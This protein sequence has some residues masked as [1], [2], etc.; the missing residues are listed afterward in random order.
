VLGT[1]DGGFVVD[2]AGGEN[3]RRISMTKDYCPDGGS[4]HC[5]DPHHV[6]SPTAL[7]DLSDFNWLRHARHAGRAT[8]CCSR[9]DTLFANTHLHPCPIEFKSSPLRNDFARHRR[10]HG[11]E[12][13]S[14]H[15][16]QPRH[17]AASVF[18]FE[19]HGISCMHDQYL[20]KVANK[21]DLTQVGTK[22]LIPSSKFQVL[23]DLMTR[24]TNMPYESTRQQLFECLVWTCAPT[25]LYEVVDS[26][27]QVPS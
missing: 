13:R 25:L 15:R 23:K 6:C 8:V 12:H 9:G 27:F 19:L 14:T 21:Y 5:E 4:G 2:V 10:Q 3:G 26:K 20:F 7:T 17:R 16:R 18:N 11:G 22:S 24:Q 1:V